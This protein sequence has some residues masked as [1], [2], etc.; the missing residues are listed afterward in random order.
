MSLLFVCV[1]LPSA[2]CVGCCSLL[3]FVVKGFV[4]YH[5]LAFAVVFWAAPC[6]YSLYVVAARGI[7]L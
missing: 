5:Y 1:M 6:C 7:M 2:V 3:L 4:V